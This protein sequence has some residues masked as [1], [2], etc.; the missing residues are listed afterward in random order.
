[1]I[2]LARKSRDLDLNTNTQGFGPSREEKLTSSQK[3]KRT[4]GKVGNIIGVMRKKTRE[5]RSEPKPVVVE[6]KPEVEV[7]VVLLSGRESMRFSH[8]EAMND[9]DANCRFVANAFHRIY[10][11]RGFRPPQKPRYKNVRRGGARQTA[12]EKRAREMRKMGFTY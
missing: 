11:T 10:Y 4:G 9:L 6:E 8:Y 12:Q 2:R 3:K 1:M 5:Q 7:T